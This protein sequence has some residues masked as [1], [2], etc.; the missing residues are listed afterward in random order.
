MDYGSPNRLVNGDILR[1][2]FNGLWMDA[3]E[4]SERSGNKGLISYA[5]MSAIVA[6]LREKGAQRIGYAALPP[7]IDVGLQMAIA[8]LD[9]NKE[10]MKANL[11]KSV[12]L[13]GGAGGLSLIWICLGQLLNPGVVATVV[14][15]FA[16]GIAGGIL[17]PIGIVGG[18]SL[19]VASLYSS[20]QKMTPQERT[21]KCHSVVMK[22]IDRW[23]KYGDKTDLTLEEKQKLML[24]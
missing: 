6:T 11:K 5:D 9:P 21:V 4:R 19:I 15:F 13:A 20:M 12:S 8:A 23:I 14:A 22:A 1:T 18:I 7:T 24:R 16:G 2:Y 3:L 10:R 17:A